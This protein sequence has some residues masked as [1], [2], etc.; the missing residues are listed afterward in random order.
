MTRHSPLAT[1]GAM[2][3]EYGGVLIVPLI[4]GLVE[5][6]KRLGLGAVYAAPLAVALGLGISVGYALAGSLPGGAALAD[7]VL[8][9]LALGLSAA[10]LYSGAKRWRDGAGTER[11]A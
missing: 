4:V 5:A 6:G 9:G 7:A 10:G 8:R 11:R 1:G 3:A 2:D